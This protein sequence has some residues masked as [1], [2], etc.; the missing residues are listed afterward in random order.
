MTPILVTAA[1]ASTALAISITK[2]R[3]LA[4]AGVLDKRYIGKGT[5][6]YRITY[7]SVEAYAASLSQDPKVAS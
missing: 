4:D 6:N 3:E 7:A 2:V 5:R 1:D